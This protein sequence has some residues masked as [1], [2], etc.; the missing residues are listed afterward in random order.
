MWRA[1]DIND[2]G[3]N[4]AVWDKVTMPKKKGGLGVK[5]LY[6]HN[7]ALLFKHLNKFYNKVDIPWVHVIYHS[8]YQL[9]V[10]HLTSARGSFWWK[11]ICKL[12]VQFRGI[13]HCNTSMG[14]LARL[15]EDSLHQLPFS[16]KYPIMYSFASAK[17]LYLKGGLDKPSLLD[18]FKLPMSRMAYNEFL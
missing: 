8:Y 16:Q 14:D 12:S 4:L 6:L 7:D 2:K 17:S 11:D 9:R 13:A 15:W 3:Y 10:P 5:N 1:A 18:L